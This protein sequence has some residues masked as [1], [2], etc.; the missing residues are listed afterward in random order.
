MVATVALGALVAPAGAARPAEMV[1]R[2]LR[3]EGLRGRA[4]G[5]TVVTAAPVD[6]AGTVVAAQVVHPLLLFA[7]VRRSIWARRR[8]S[9]AWVARVARLL[10]M[11]VQAA[12][13]NRVWAATWKSDLSEGN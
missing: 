13:V 3:A 5:A 1:A 7:L 8:S 4:R 12:S 10:G 9:R 11:R 6:E 2:R